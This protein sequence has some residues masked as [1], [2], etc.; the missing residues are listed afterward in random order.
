[1]IVVTGARGVIGRALI[2][3]LRAERLP[4]MALGRDVLA[5]TSLASL[6]LAV[7]RRPSVVVHLAAAVPQP[8]NISD[9]ES[10]AERTRE[11]DARVLEA[12]GEW[13]CH[14][15][16]ASGCS[17]YSKDG[18]T[19]R[20]EDEA[21]DEAL[22]HASPYLSAKQLGE[23]TFLA[24]GRATVL[25]ISAPIGEGLPN[26]TVVGRF[27]ESAITGGDLEVWGGGQREQNY[28]DVMDLAD[29]LFRSFI[30]RP[31]ELINIAADQPITMHQLAQ[32]VVRACGCGTVRMTSKPDP[33]D[34]EK[35]RYSNQRAADIL[36]WCPETSIQ[37]SLDHLQKYV[38]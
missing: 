9:D 6:V 37:A 27:M 12:V 5:G 34:G 21:L 25:R 19:P 35:A 17:L 14:A 3:R 31:T 15:I 16:Y 13:G 4:F 38:Q 22:V 20:R 2:M 33:R 32:E 26:S 10:A 1:V 36:G 7:P 29:A 24:S 18:G 28:V 11:M 23:H 8:P 30:V